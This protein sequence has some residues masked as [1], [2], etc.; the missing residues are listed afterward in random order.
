[1]ASFLTEND[2]NIQ[3]EAPA[4]V[5]MTLGGFQRNLAPS[6][7]HDKVNGVLEVTNSTHP[8]SPSC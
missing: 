1:M 3:F 8:G 4:T 5:G 7:G 6:E 2:T